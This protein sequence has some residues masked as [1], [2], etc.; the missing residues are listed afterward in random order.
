MILGRKSIFAAIVLL[1][2]MVFGGGGGGAGLANL[3]VQLTALVLLAVEPQAVLNFFTRVARFPAVLVAS[4]LLLPLLQLVPLPPILWQALPGRSLA[5]EALA[6]VGQQDSWLPMSV[7]PGRTLVAFASLLPPLAILVFSWDRPREEKRT[8]LMLVVLVA[9]LEV[10][11]G[12]QQ[13]ASGNRSLIFFDEALGSSDL[14][15]TFANRNSMGLFFVL[16]L[17][18]VVG[19]VPEKPRDT[20]VLVGLCA[21][22]AILVL[23]LVLT[24]SRSSMGLLV[25]PFALAA[26]R[27]LRLQGSARSRIWIGSGLALVGVIL[28]GGVTMLASDNDRVRASLER[29]SDLEDRRPVIW[30]DTLTSIGRF[31]PVGS[32]VGTFDEVFQVDESLENI[33]PGRAGRAHDEYLE[34]ALESGVVGLALLGAWCV[35]WALRGLQC[36]RA[37]GLGQVGIAAF[38][39][40]MLQSIS[41]YPLRS[42]T[43][44]CIAGLAMALVVSRGRRMQSAGARREVAVAR[45]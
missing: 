25:I 35:F 16:S 5:Q 20:K 21:V 22:A 29:F 36:L 26:F 18:F 2:G 3:A 39:V 37:G 34:V 9:V 10:L 24:R 4:A 15:G 12:A 27:W 38:A 7:E 43:L 42:Q 30:A 23:G 32:G 41:D 6:L 11:L 1:V 13:L 17:C 31:W 28:A 40:V 44:L 45:E 8:L 14:Q 19:L 33:G